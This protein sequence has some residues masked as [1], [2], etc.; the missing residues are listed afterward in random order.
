ML[1]R[2]LKR[3]IENG[4]TDGLEEKIDIFYATDKL[5]EEEYTEL[6][7]MLPAKGPAEETGGE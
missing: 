4:R 2:T 5:T 1:Y 3:L 6:V 7:A